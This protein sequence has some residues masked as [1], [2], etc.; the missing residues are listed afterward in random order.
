[1]SVLISICSKYPNPLLYECID[2]LYK[3]QINMD[4]NYLYKIHVV[5]SDSTDFIYYNK[6]QE[7]FPDVEIHMIKNTNYEY[8][9]WKYILNKYPS[10][11]IYICIQDSIIIKNFI[12]L[13]IL[14]NKTA[15]TFH[16]HTGY[17]SHECVKGIGILKLKDSDLNYE[18][19]IDTSF[20][21]AC[22]SSFI[23]NKEI[24]QDIFAH[25]TI[26]PINKNGS[27][28]YE[29]IFG[30]YFLAKDIKTNDLYG[31]LMHKYHG[32]RD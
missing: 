29:R 13:N 3:K 6:I 22:H 26:P 12:N 4:K 9:A 30:I 7:D 23:V 18:P 19:I 2:E 5:D 8:G 16:N 10:F 27:C 25:L 21:L 32:K 28:S 24:F 31:G 1:M 17:H 15:Y 11:D 20:N 14:D